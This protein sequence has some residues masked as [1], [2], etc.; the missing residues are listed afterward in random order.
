M[1][2]EG[3]DNGNQEKLRQVVLENSEAGEWDA[4]IHEWDL[5]Y[6]YEERGSVCACGHSPI[7]DNCLIRNRVNGNTLVVG[8]VCINHFNVPSLNVPASACQLLKTG[9]PCID[10]PDC[11]TVWS[12]CSSSCCDSDQGS[13]SVN[14]DG[15]AG[16]HP[17]NADFKYIYCY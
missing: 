17:D 16:D 6:I 15:S 8:N 12:D 9:L 4:A 14:N 10:S 2:G 11:Q 5:A 13:I 1:D 3:N 7:T